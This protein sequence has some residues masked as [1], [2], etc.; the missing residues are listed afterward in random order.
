MPRTK[1]KVPDLRSAR[2]DLDQIRIP[3]VFLEHEVETLRN[4]KTD[5]AM[6]ADLFTELS[7]RVKNELELP[8]K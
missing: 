2:V 3:G 4:D 6:L 5:R 7:L 1:G 8:E